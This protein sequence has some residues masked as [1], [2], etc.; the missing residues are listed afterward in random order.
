MAIVQT[1]W[2][3]TVSF[4]ETSGKAV[5]RTYEAP[6][7]AFVDYD[8]FE[9]LVQVAVTGFIASVAAITDSVISSYQLEGVYIEDALALPVGAEN[10]V[11]A[12]FSGK[13]A[14]DP[15]D[16]GTLS[17]PAPVIGAFQTPTGPGYDIVDMSDPAVLQFINFFTDP[18]GPFT[19]SDGEL[20][21]LTTVKGTRRTVK[22][23]NT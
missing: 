2:R 14:G 19:I 3:L 7:A 12:F 23:S 6:L 21:E 13:I 16:S 1:G 17:V 10:Q 15:T 18:G 8:A 9:T 20:L 4:T 22:A 11:Q 5:T